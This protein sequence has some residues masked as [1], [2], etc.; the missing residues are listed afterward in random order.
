MRASRMICLR[1]GQTAPAGSTRCP[2]CAQPLDADTGGEMAR[3]A[4][5]TRGRS[6][7]ALLPGQVVAD[8]FEVRTLVAEGPTGLLYRAF[9]ED[10]E[11]EVALKIIH[12]ELLPDW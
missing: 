1:C 3:G 12:P 9:D 7:A 10:V 8:R 6:G 4:A 11:I 2:I 5:V